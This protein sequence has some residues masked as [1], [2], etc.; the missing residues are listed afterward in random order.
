MYRITLINWREHNPGKKK[1]HKKTMIANNL[2]SDA[3]VLALTLS[4]RWLFI[5]LLL[6]AGDHA[7]DTITLTQR[8]V[9][10]ILTT[11]EGAQNALDR[12]Q[13][14]QLVT[15]EKDESLITEK[16]NNRRITEKKN[17]RREGVEKIKIEAKSETDE[18]KLFVD[19]IGSPNPLKFNAA[20]LIKIYC[21]DWKIS[22]RSTQSPVISPKDAKAMKNF[23]DTVG[24]E[25]AENIVRAYLKMPDK[26]FLTKK[27]DIPTLIAN[28]NAVIHFIETGRVITS[29]ELSTID[30]NLATENLINDIKENGI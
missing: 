12:L 25:R 23:L 22:Y 1:T 28:T 10:D 7:N 6:I 30:R 26:W 11:K 29:K 17:N 2:I 8:Q 3:K 14:F 20:T 13:S 9:N 19:P 27:H 21:E 16:K 15:F 24:A 18:H 4:Q 5:N